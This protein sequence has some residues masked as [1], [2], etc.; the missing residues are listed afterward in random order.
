MC[1]KKFKNFLK[2]CISQTKCAGNFWTKAHR[3][4]AVRVSG[5]HAAIHRLLVGEEVQEIRK[6]NYD[7]SGSFLSPQFHR[8]QRKKW[9]LTAFTDAL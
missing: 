9:L 4:D 6:R 1:R 2:K 8:K 5:W 7:N 3:T